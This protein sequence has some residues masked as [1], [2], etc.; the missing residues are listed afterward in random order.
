MPEATQPPRPSPTPPP[1]S[2]TTTAAKTADV[3]IHS[4]FNGAVKSLLVSSGLSITFQFTLAGREHRHMERV[5]IVQHRGGGGGGG[6][7]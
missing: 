7:L 1:T 5:F 6:S 4:I 2:P 3:F